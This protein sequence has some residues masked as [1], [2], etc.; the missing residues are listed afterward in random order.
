MLNIEKTI[1][2]PEDNRIIFHSL[3]EERHYMLDIYDKYIRTFT[4]AA[5]ATYNEEMMLLNDIIANFTAHETGLMYY[6]GKS[7]LTYKSLVQAHEYGY[8]KNSKNEW[9]YRKYTVEFE[10]GFKATTLLFN[11]HKL[12]VGQEYEFEFKILTGKFNA[13][14]GCSPQYKSIDIIREKKV[15][16][17]KSKL[18]AA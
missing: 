6:K 5:L 11:S 7:R 4:M 18:M 1:I 3:T 9:Q 10:N 8:Y 13:F 2:T 12:E 15:R 14:K 17:V 16:K